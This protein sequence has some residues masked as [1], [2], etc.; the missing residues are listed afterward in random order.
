VLQQELE[1]LRS[2]L[3]RVDRDPLRLAERFAWDV[4]AVVDAQLADH[5]EAEAAGTCVGGIALA[6]VNFRRPEGLTLA[7]CRYRVVAGQAVVT[8]TLPD[9]HTIERP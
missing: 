7:A 9:G 8:M 1:V 2:D 6:G 4:L 5:P 3:S